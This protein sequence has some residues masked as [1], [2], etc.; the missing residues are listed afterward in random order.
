MEDPR[1]KKLARVLVDYCTEVQPGDV[2][3]IEGS[4]VTR[5]LMAAI[6]R[7]VLEAGGHPTVY[8]IFEDAS[9]L[10]LEYGDGL[11]LRFEDPVARYIVDNVDVSITLL[12]SEN[13]KSLSSY[14]PAKQ[15]LLIGAEK[16]RLIRL[17]QRAAIGKL[18][19]VVTQFP[20]PAAAQDAHMS[21]SEYERF[22]FGAGML[23]LRDPLVFWRK[24]QAQQERMVEFL[25][26]VE[27]LRFVTPQGTDLRV[28]VAGRRWVNCCGKVNFPDGEVFTGPLEDVTEG[29]L[30]MSFPAVYQGREVEGIRLHFRQGRVTEAR[31]MRNESFLLEMLNQDKGARV[32]GEIGLGTNYA[33]TQYTRNT[34]FDEKMGGTFHLA[35]GASYPETGGTNES[36]LHWDLVVDLRQGG[37][38]YADGTLIQ[39]NGVFLKRGWPQPRRRS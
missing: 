24:L 23:Q 7:A 8:M 32:A 37:K 16:R 33:I 30:V 21:L 26:G 36:G 2:V 6:Y 9:W 31:A 20:C 25:Q 14:D 27:E 19:W 38:I 28:G 17:M 4:P 15:A 13:T 12:G 39:Q 3:L 18:R 22:V 11:Q 29:T 35:L 10:K 34:L 5:P 1:Y